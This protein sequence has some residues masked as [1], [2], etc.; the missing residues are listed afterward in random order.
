M[1]CGAKGGASVASRPWSVEDTGRLVVCSSSG[2]NGQKETAQTVEN[3]S[4]GHAQGV[5]RPRMLGYAR[6]HSHIRRDWGKGRKGQPERQ[7]RGR[8]K[9]F[10]RPAKGAE[11][12]G[13][14]QK[15]GKSD[16]ETCD[17][18]AFA[19]DC[20]PLSAFS[21]LFF[22]AGGFWA[23]RTG[24]TGGSQPKECTRHPAGKQRF[25]SARN[26]IGFNRRRTATG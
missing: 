21:R 16:V 9:L 3:R 10:L 11:R 14:T 2:A 6:L 20:P 1:G 15:Q 24:A 18:S 19:R 23:T 4:L 25:T 26:Q 17:S 13:V 22:G 7:G 12:K 5:G 8:R